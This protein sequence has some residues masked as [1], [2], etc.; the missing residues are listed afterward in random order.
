MQRHHRIVDGMLALKEVL[1]AATTRV[2]AVDADS[3]LARLL[4]EIGSDPFVLKRNGVAW[5]VVPDDDGFE[6][7]VALE[8]LSEAIGSWSGIVS[9]EAI[10]EMNANRESDSR[11]HDRRPR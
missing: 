9:E 8:A 11:S 4:D 5:F 7:E 1:M 2:V 10:D 3:D 6:P